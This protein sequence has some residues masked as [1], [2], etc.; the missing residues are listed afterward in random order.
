[1]RGGIYI[2]NYIILTSHFIAHLQHFNKKVRARNNEFLLQLPPSMLHSEL[3]E[4]IQKQNDPNLYR[5]FQEYLPLTFSRRHG[6]PSRPWNMFNINVK[7]E[8]GNMRISYQ[9]NWRDI[10]QNWEALSLSYPGYIHS[11]LAKFLNASTADGYNPYKITSEGIEWEVIEPDN[12]WSNIGYWGDHQIIYLL[13]LM[14]ISNNYFP[15]K[16]EEWLNK[17]LFAYANIP[18]RLKS[19]SEIVANP[20]DTVSFDAFLNGEIEKQAITLGS[21]AKLITNSQGEVMLVSLTE[22]LL[23]SLLS[24]L[25]NFI[26]GA[27]IWMNTLRPEW[28]D[29]NNALV[30]H[31]ASMVTLYYMRRFITFLQNIYQHS[32][33]DVLH[34]SI[35]MAQ[36]FNEME[37]IFDTRPGNMTDQQRRKMTDSLGM[38]GE[39]YRN[40]IYQGFTEK[41]ATLLRKNLLAFFE[42]ILLHIDQSIQLNQRSDGLFHSYNLVRFSNN[43]LSIRQLPEMLEGQVAVLSS[44]CL[45]AKETLLLLNV[46]R[47]STLYRADQNSY[48]L[49]PNK[50]LPDFINKNIIPETEVNALPLLSKLLNLGDNSILSKD[51]LGQHHFNAD[52]SNS[53]LLQKVLEQLKSSNLTEINENDIQ[54]VLDL[55]EKIFDHQSFTGRSGTF[56]KYEGLGCIYWH[57]VSKLLLS[58]GESI[59]KAVLSNEDPGLINELTK[60]YEEIK[61]G[62]GAHKTPA[63]YGSFPFD[64]YS[65]TPIMTGVQQPGMTGQVK[66]DILSRFFELGILVQNGQLSFNPNILHK[67]EFNTPTGSDYPFPWLSF[68]YCGVDITYFIHDTPGIEIINSAGKSSYSDNYILPVSL[69]KSLF[70]RNGEII[71]IKI[72]LAEDKLQA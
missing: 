37:Q 22:K 44:G 18:Y 72:H 17:P 13:R 35:E 23:A 47:K 64:P 45:S 25:S 39:N 66:E 5:L 16:M 11:I 10:F 2:E 46:L 55:Y 1:M 26:P 62:I 36:F 41:T 61:K 63:E 4:Y 7:D 6:D 12:P 15:G 38:A 54:Q 57:M 71:K 43:V 9:G 70:F 32:N 42:K 33:H 65:H 8:L 67:N 59:K 19:Y 53:G 51:K 3:E 14:E 58:V 56:Y 52:F 31:G 24:K 30:G 40:K 68:S 27:G 20:K 69:S 50:K 60:H 28:N 34:I 29:A 21:D 48:I 49:Y